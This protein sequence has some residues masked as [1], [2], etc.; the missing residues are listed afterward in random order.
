MILSVIKR[1]RPMLNDITI[2]FA[3]VS[4]LINDFLA[5][6]N[7]DPILNFNFLKE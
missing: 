1:A 4:G 5:I 6:S 7:K 3:N 2:D